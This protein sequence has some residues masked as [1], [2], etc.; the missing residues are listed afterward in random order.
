MLLLYL[1]SATAFALLCCGVLW[2]VPVSS[3]PSPVE[4]ALNQAWRGSL[5]TA[6]KH[7]G[8]MSTNGG[9]QEETPAG[10][11][12]MVPIAKGEAAEGYLVPDTGYAGLK[13]VHAYPP[14]Y[15]ID[16]F[17]TPE[18]CK[19][20]MEAGRPHLSRS[21]VVGG[22]DGSDAPRVSA[23]TRTSSSY[24]FPKHQL[25]WLNEKVRNRGRLVTVAGV[26]TD[27]SRALMIVAFC[28]LRWRH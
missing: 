14:I 9:K 4:A 17:L 24:F 22:K 3:H 18:E 23:P 28:Q 8:V 16:G 20:L 1:A 21:V 10:G 26:L 6:L 2:G 12:S 19:T 7:V 25:E 11:P 15:E 27:S 5:D 13:L